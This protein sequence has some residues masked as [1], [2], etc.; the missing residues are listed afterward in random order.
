MVPPVPLTRDLTPPE[1][2]VM[3]C[4]KKSVFDY[5]FPPTV[6]EICAYMGWPSTSMAHRVLAKL[7]ADGFIVKD[8]RS[9]RT[10][11]VLR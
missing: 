8:P 3:H 10:I 5:G 6:R 11:T 7:Q 9:P 4:I 1:A 2:E